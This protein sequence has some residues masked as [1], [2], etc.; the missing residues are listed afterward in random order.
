M[1][2]SIYTPDGFVERAQLSFH[3]MSTS[4]GTRQR[5]GTYLGD[6]LHNHAFE[7][8]RKKFMKMFHLSSL[9]KDSSHMISSLDEVLHDPCTDESIRACYE[10]GA[11]RQYRRH[12]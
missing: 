11:G 2:D 10:N 8:L 12:Y 9:P 6:V 4:S 5:K 1:A 7:L 3:F